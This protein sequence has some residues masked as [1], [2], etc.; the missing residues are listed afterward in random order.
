MREAVAEAGDRL[1]VAGQLRDDVDIPF[2]EPCG[3]GVT[4]VVRT[5]VF[6]PC[7]LAHRSVSLATRGNENMSG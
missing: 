2:D 4:Q 3:E 7:A 6:K 1:G 5:K